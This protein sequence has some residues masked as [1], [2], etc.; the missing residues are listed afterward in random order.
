MTI[1]TDSPINTQSR[2]SRYA[3]FAALALGANGIRIPKA[4]AL[5][6]ERLHG[7]RRGDIHPRK[8]SDLDKKARER[9]R[10]QAKIECEFR[11][12]PVTIFLGMSSNTIRRNITDEWKRAGLTVPLV[13]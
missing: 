1:K 8:L 2:A 7:K 4:D 6:I 11:A 5:P 12:E 9:M 10:S 13:G 3:V